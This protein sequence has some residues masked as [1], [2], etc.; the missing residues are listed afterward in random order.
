MVCSSIPLGKVI[1]KRRFT[2]F[3]YLLCILPSLLYAVPAV[4]EDHITL[5]LRWDHQFQ[6][7]GYYAAQ[8]QGYYRAEGIRVDIKPAVTKS[9]IRSAVQEVVEGRAE[10]GVGAA[11]ILKGR[12]EGAD[13]VLVASLFQHSAAA[14]YTRKDTVIQ[15]PADFLNLRVARRVNDLIDIELQAMLK[16]EGIDPR[17]ITPYPH[18]PGISHLIN[19][20][21]DVIPGYSINIPYT[22]KVNGYSLNEYRPIVYG[23]DFY[24]DS[25]FTSRK[26]VESN[27][28][29]VE[30]FTLATIKGWEYAMSHKEELVQK[31]STELTRYG[32]IEDLVAFNRNQSQAME[33]LI[34]PEQVE[35]GHI[36]PQRWQRMHD[37]L[38]LLGLLKNDLDITSFVFNPERIKALEAKKRQI[39]LT[40]AVGLAGSLLILTLL[41]TY[42]LRAAVGRKTRDLE[43]SRSDLK[44]S[45][46]RFDLAMQFTNDGLYDWNT[47]TGDTYFSPGWKQMLGYEDHEIQNDLSEWE[48]LTEPEGKNKALELIEELLTG[49]RSRYE[50]EFRMRHKDGHWVDIL[51]RGNVTSDHRGKLCRVVGTHVDIS[52]RKKKERELS[53]KDAAIENSLNGFDIVDEDGL[54]VYVNRAYV[55]MWGYES[56]EEIIGTSPAGHCMDPLMPEKIIGVLKEKGSWVFELVARKKDGTPFDVLMY[57]RLTHDENG[58]EIYPSTSIDITERKRGRLERERLEK[59]LHHTQKMESIGNL[60]GGIAHDF[61]NILASVLGFTELALEDAIPG[62][63]Q[64]DSLKEVYTSGTRARDLVRQILAFARQS[65]EVK[66]PVILADTVGEVLKMIRATLPSNIEIRSD[67][68]GRGTVLGNKTQ[69]HQVLM[70]L[71]T[72]AGYAMRTN[73]GVLRVELL[74]TLVEEAGH[75]SLLGVEPGKYMELRISD[76]GDGID[77]EVLDKI[78]EPLLSG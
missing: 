13:L 51:S 44:R 61:N 4:A 2:L 3:F 67:L 57:A 39:L 77:P 25:L 24:G 19:K 52:E 14:F 65:D 37:Y 38:H 9:G 30:R 74:E 33:K 8:W 40:T 7:A 78:F 6:F 29:L 68:S 34:W 5:Q 22:A 32:K 18:K 56:D 41:W 31:I 46:E 50:T 55:E 53:L 47:E 48:R 10:F 35:L 69:L 45:K 60:A 27:P 71:C 1:C 12:D 70:N 28:D 21:V 43:K 64:E 72:N 58:R 42:F 73:G 63:S 26:L 66:S 54:F 59:R 62:S 16:V 36:N 23:I 75:W 15:S 49:K 20:E 76:T 11:D 17:K